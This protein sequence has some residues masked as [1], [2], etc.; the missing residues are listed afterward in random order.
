LRESGG[1]LQDPSAEF[2]AET[3]PQMHFGVQRGQKTHLVVANVLIQFGFWCFFNLGFLG[4]LLLVLGY[5]YA[6]GG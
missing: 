1:A 2:G 3:R 5:A 6:A 4:L